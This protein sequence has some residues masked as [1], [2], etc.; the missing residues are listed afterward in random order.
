MNS[1]NLMGRPAKPQLAKARAM[2]WARDVQ[3]RTNLPFSSIDQ[4]FLYVDDT[5]PP[6]EPPK[7]FERIYRDGRFAGKG[8]AAHRRSLPELVSFIDQQ[9]EFKST[10]VVFR[11]DIW[12]FLQQNI[13]SRA[14]LV[15][16]IDKVFSDHSV[17]RYHIPKPTNNNWRRDP[18]LEVSNP[19]NPIEWLRL[20]SANLHE[21]NFF[22]LS[23]ILCLYIKTT[24]LKD[25]EKLLLNMTKPFREYLSNRLG[26]F[27]ET[28]YSE[29]LQKINQMQV[30]HIF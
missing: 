16:R 24:I 7:V 19:I 4:Q 3:D 29:V 22:Y 10:A 18:E 26:S 1:P 15:D 25:D 30:V 20:Q 13:V 23:L 12:E 27:G 21:I 2:L 5:N 11:C 17:E 8:K 9:P 14:S 6:L 28:C